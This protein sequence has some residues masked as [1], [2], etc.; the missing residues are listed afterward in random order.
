MGYQI[1]DGT[2]ATKL[3]R[4]GGLSATHHI[5]SPFKRISDHLDSIVSNAIHI[6]IYVHIRTFRQRFQ[7]VSPWTRFCLIAL[8]LSYQRRI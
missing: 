6:S 7:L 1:Q 4:G 3:N 5:D 8:I 2:S